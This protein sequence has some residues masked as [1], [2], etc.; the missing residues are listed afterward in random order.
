[1]IVKLDNRFFNQKQEDNQIN[2][3]IFIKMIQDNIYI[4]RKLKIKSQMI[5]NNK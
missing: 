1:M 4:K 5:I 3:G 2:R